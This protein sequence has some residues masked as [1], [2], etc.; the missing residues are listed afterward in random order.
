MYNEA[1]GRISAFLIFIGFNVTF[2]PQFILGYLGMP[3]RYHVYPPEFQFLNIL[4]SAGSTILAVGYIFPMVYSSTR[5]GSGSGRRR[6]PGT[7]AASN[8][9]WPS[10]PPAHNFLT[11]PQCP[12]GALRLPDP[13]PRDREAA[14]V[15]AGA[16]DTA[17]GVKLVSHFATVEQ[18]KRA[19]V[20]GMWAWLL[21]ELLLFAGLFLTALILRLLHPEAIQAAARHLKFWIGAVNT[22]VLIGSSLTMSG[23][24]SSSRASAGSAAWCGSCSTPP[25]SARC[26]SCSRATSTTPTTTST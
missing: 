24:R 12:E 17:V 5:S 6:T 22:V 15:S 10:P 16:T 7:P 21:T 20:L 19:A 13:G 4:S 25:R 11:E 9:P 18:Q 14:L 2:F 23:A 26:S 1:W 3:R 8:G